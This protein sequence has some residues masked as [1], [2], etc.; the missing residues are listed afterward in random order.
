MY[1]LGSGST[2]NAAVVE[3]GGTRVLVDAGFGPRSAVH[4]LRVLG[5]D[6]FPR[7]VDAIVVSHQHGDH[8]GHLEPLARALRCPV[9]LHRGIEAK[10]V[11]ARF[12]VRELEPR[13]PVTI[14]AI[15]LTAIEV[16]HDSPQVAMRLSGQDAT[17]GIATDVGAVT[18]ELVRFFAACDGALLEA[19]HCPEL[20]R[21][22]PYPERLK[23]R[24][25]GGLGHL[26]NGQTA[27]IVAKLSGT[28]M[29]RIWLGHISRANNT[30]EL[31][32]KT[33]RAAARGIDVAVLGH[34]VPT[35]LRLHPRAPLSFSFD[36]G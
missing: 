36:R 15:E 25:S 17:F 29:R 21:T 26:S 22:G 6:L 34:G 4:R 24:V 31:A 30:P 14:G 12:E 7:G 33:V 28:R 27:E 23:K 9:Y 18:R 35:A 2:G 32:L 8:A 11:R 3:S 13:R 10:R 20:L 1:V 19:N 5:A 16:P